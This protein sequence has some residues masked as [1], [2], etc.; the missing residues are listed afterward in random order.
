MLS[1]FDGNTNLDFVDFFADRDML[2]Q[3][4]NPQNPTR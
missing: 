1:T 2:Q 3:E 4:C